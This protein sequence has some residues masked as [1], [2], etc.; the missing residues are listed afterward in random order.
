MPGCPEPTLP[1]KA[2][3]AKHQK[4]MLQAK[5]KVRH[6]KPKVPYG[7]GWRELSKAILAAYPL[8]KICGRPSEVVHHIIERKDGGTDDPTNLVALCNRCHSSYHWHQR[9]NTPA[10]RAKAIKNYRK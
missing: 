8:C 6:S 4:E 10:K 7:K 5:R 2:R 1:H 9:F 3:C